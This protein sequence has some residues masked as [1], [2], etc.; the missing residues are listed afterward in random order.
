MDQ[1]LQLAQVNDIFSIQSTVSVN[2]VEFRLKLGEKKKF[3]FTG[4]QIEKKSSS[5][6][7]I[8][9]HPFHYYILDTATDTIIFRGRFEKIENERR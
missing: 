8:A 1:R 2:D 3:H 4:I 7:F 6:R 5:P 9:N